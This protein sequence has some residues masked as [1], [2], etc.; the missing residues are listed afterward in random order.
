V[1]FNADWRFTL[2]DVPGAYTPDFNDA[3]WEATGLPHSF[4][5]PY[6]RAPSFYVGFGWYR[7]T[8]SLAA[9]PAGRRFTLEFEG[10]FQEAEV[11]VDG[12]AASHHRGGY[13][14]F[15]VGIT[16]FLHPGTNVIAVRV[17]NNWDAT[18]APRAGEH[19]FSGGLYR[20]SQS[21]L[22]SMSATPCYRPLKRLSILPTCEPRQPTGPPRIT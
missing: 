20:D 15:P 19:V 8:L 9:V 1:N 14:G 22:S 10:A 5:N 6:F 13:T 17:N 3:R 12:W 11:Y 2:S 7:K 16:N 4:S 21:D 18:L